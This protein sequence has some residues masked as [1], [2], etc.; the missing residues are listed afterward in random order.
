M[1]TLGNLVKV[2][3]RTSNDTMVPKI[4]ANFCKIWATLVVGAMY[5]AMSTTVP[6]QDLT[7]LM[8]H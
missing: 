6:F 4:M 5:R 8:D 7:I 1:A 3:I 2:C